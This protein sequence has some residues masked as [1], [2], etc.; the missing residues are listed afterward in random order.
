MEQCEHCVSIFSDNGKNRRYFGRR[1]SGPD[2]LY[3]PCGVALSATIDILVCDQSNNRIHVFSPDGKSLR[4]VGNCGNGPLRFSYPFGIAVHPHVHSNKIY[5][6][7]NCNH[8]VQILNDDILQHF[9][10]ISIDST[11]NVYV[12]YNCNYRIQLTSIHSRW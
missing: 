9:C 12:A 6:A 11:G 3:H 5:V 1:G 10:A 7:D 2:Q 8:R 4:C